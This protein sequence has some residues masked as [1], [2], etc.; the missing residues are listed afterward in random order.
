MAIILINL[1]YMYQISIA[2]DK[3]CMAMI[4]ATRQMFNIMLQKHMALNTCMMHSLPV[5][6]VKLHH[7][8]IKLSI[9]N[10]M[11]ETRWIA[12][13]SAKYILMQAS[14]LMYM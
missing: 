6:Y 3:F 9:D 4:Y 10:Y 13:Y 5:R 11:A 2:I 1:N 14:I 12:A 7:D 8:Q